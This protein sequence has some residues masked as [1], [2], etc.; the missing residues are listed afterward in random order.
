MRLEGQIKK[1]EKREI[2]KY[3]PQ[4]DET[5]DGVPCGVI[6]GIS[7][8]IT[9]QKTPD[10][11]NHTVRVLKPKSFESYDANG[12]KFIAINKKLVFTNFLE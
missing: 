8:G 3:I 1:S 9:G 7:K 2:D 10:I 12:C 11:F 6:V 5:D 4:P